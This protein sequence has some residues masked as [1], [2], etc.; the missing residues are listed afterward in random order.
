[1]GPAWAR[2]AACVQALG[3]TVFHVPWPIPPRDQATIVF[4][5][6]L[7]FALTAV[8]IAAGVP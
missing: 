1:M 4:A 3:G 7:G 5:F 8:V 6:L 2:V